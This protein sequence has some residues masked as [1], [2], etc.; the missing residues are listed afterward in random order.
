[1]KISSI[2]RLISNYLITFA[3][4][5]IQL[6]VFFCIK[7][8]I[9]EGISIKKSSFVLKDKSTVYIDQKAKIGDNVIIFENVHIDGAS[10]IEE[11]VTIYPNTYISN[12]IIGKGSKIYS[13]FIE[14]SIIGGCCL[15]SP[16]VT[17]KKGTMLSNNV[18]VGVSCCLKNT[19]IGA[20]SKLHGNNFI[21]NANVQENV[22]FGI[23]ASVCPNS[24]TAE[25]GAGSEILPGVTITSNKI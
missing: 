12:S 7:C 8:G 15:I 21:I 22:T 13:A 1:M 5:L 14:K 9:K 6:F 24:G 10:V 17:L 2:I 16:F 20:H 11:N 3:R 4:V 18:Y 25:I 19:S 23:G